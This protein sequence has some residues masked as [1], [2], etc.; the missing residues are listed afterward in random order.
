MPAMEYVTT[1][2]LLHHW[3]ALV[4]AGYTHALAENLTGLL[5]RGE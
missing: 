2:H 3:G 5:A 4:G 1:Y